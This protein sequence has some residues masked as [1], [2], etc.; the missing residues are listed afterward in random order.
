MQNRQWQQGQQAEKK[1]K[2]GGRAPPFVISTTGFA[3]FFQD[4]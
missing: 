4:A 1:D 2:H 3:D